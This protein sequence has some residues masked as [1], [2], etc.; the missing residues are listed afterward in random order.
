MYAMNLFLMPPPRAVNSAMRL[1]EANVPQTRA[2]G[3]RRDRQPGFTVRARLRDL[4]GGLRR[5]AVDF[6]RGDHPAALAHRAAWNARRSPA[7]FDRAAGEAAR[8]GFRARRGIGARA[9]LPGIEAIAAAVDTASPAAEAI[10]AAFARFPM[11][12]RGSCRRPQNSQPV[13]RS[14][15]CTRRFAPRPTTSSS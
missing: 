6:S 9:E 8:A 3:S 10:R 2:N 11:Y 13:R 15:I 5:L 4:L 7:R 1:F 12:P 14:T